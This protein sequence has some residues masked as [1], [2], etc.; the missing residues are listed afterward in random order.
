VQSLYHHEGGSVS[1]DLQ[2]AAAHEYALAGID[3]AHRFIRTWLRQETE[4]E[5]ALTN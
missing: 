2:D 5:N 4:A 1:A 3:P